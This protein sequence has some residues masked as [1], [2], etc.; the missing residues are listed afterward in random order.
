M[1]VWIRNPIRIQIGS[2]G[3]VSVSDPDPQLRRQKNIKKSC[4]NNLDFLSGFP[5]NNYM[6]L[7]EVPVQKMYRYRTVVYI[8]HPVDEYVH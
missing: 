6:V 5:M 7:D 8:C 2:G 1:S 3:Q 4:C